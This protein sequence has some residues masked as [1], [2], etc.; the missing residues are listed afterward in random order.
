MYATIL[1]SAIVAS[2]APPWDYYD[3]QTVGQQEG[4]RTGPEPL[5]LHIRILVNLQDSSIHFFSIRVEHLPNRLYT[6]VENR[7][8]VGLAI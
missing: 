8:H 1:S 4:T 2:V 6:I 3:E 7:R 5:Q